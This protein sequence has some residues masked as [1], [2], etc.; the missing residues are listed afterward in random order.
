MDAVSDLVTGFMYYD[1]KE[2]EELPRGSIEEALEM[3]EV[4]IDEIVDKFR[5]VLSL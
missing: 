1:R 3:G 2:D 4:T 5:S